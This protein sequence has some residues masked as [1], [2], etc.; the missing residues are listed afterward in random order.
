MKEAGMLTVRANEGAVA[1]IRAKAAISPESYGRLPA[2][3]KLRAFT[4]AAAS[5]VHTL[6]AVLDALA[7]LPAGADWNAKRREIAGLLGGGAEADA[8][9]RAAMRARAALIVR[10]V[11][12]QAYAAARYAE[13]KEQADVFPYWRYVAVGD[14]RTR[15][16]HQALDG[17]VLPQDDAFWS[18]HYPPWD[19]GCRCTVEP[20]TEAEAAEAGVDDA[21]RLPGAVP[22][23]YRFDPADLNL[24]PDELME[25]YGEE[26]P[27]FCQ[28]MRGMTVDAPRGEKGHG[29][30]TAWDFWWRT[31]VARKDGGELA[32][33]AGRTGNE[34]AVIRDAETGRVAATL[35]GDV[36]GVAGV[37]EVYDRLEAEGRT[38]R[39]MHVHPAGGPFP[40]PGD[41]LIALHQA[42]AGERVTSGMGG[43]EIRAAVKNEALVKKVEGFRAGLDAGSVSVQDWQRWFGGVSRNGPVT[44]TRGW[45]L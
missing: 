4:T 36:H 14:E 11:G 38:A 13:M 30:E 20:L 18:T 24:D 25:G 42:S 2:Q 34:M 29:Q 15:P 32:R 35:R 17:V 19:W 12:R 28:A 7:D 22:D 27:D 8:D 6:R 10:T 45:E 41:V 26:W 16:E 40:S 23:G 44:M 33:Y 21:A 9:V 1:F 37:K 5:D 3:L 39:G 43:C 31:E